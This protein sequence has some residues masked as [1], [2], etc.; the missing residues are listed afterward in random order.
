MD[1]GVRVA[2]LS[3]VTTITWNQAIGS[4]WSDLLRGLV[5]GLPVGPG[6]GD[7]TCLMSATAGTS[8]TDLDIPNPDEAFW[9]VVQ[10]G[11]ACGKGPYGFAVLAGVPTP[12]VSATCP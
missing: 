4:T 2:Q 8:A 3:G 6:G 10:G 12:R 1:N 9:Y 7:E 11:N 5:G